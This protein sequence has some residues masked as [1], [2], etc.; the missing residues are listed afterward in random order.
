MLLSVQSQPRLLMEAG[1]PKIL[2]LLLLTTATVLALQLPCSSTARFS[3]QRSRWNNQF[4]HHVSPGPFSPR[5]HQ[6]ERTRSSLTLGKS[7]LDRQSFYST[8]STTTQ[9]PSSPVSSKLFSSRARL[10]QVQS[11]QSP[12]PSS[13]AL[14]MVLTTPESIIEQASTAKL[15]DDLI[16]ESVRTSARRPIM[17]QFDPSSGFVRSHSL[18]IVF[19][20]TEKYPIGPPVL[21]TFFRLPIAFLLYLVSPNLLPHAPFSINITRTTTNYQNHRFGDNGREQSFP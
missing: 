17:M 6:R 10:R 1:L 12:Q 16:D 13:T 21:L 7:I 9:A 8:P 18:Q 20:R 14:H 3:S 5:K 2:V 4:N 11:S 15:L 19:T